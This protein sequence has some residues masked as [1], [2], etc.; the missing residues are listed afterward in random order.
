MLEKFSN[1]LKKRKSILFLV[2]LLAVLIFTPF[3]FSVYVQTRTEIVTVKIIDKMQLGNNTH[4]N[5]KEIVDNY[6]FLIKT[7]NETF[8]SSI[9]SVKGSYNVTDIYMGLK[10]GSTYKLRVS[11]VGKGAFTDYRTI[12]RI[13]SLIKDSVLVD[14]ILDKKDTLVI[15]QK[16]TV[17]KFLNTNT[18]NIK[19]KV[20]KHSRIWHFINKNKN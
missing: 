11:G 20:K 9:N 10:V 15:I 6:L 17:I 12:I 14:T 16:D 2:G 3:V 4:K 7:P 13:D 5:K 18:N 19:P 1:L 8:L